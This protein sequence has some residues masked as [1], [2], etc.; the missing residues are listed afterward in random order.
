[1]DSSC[2]SFKTGCLTK[3]TGC[4]DSTKLCSDY[5]GIQSACDA[6]RGNNGTIRCWAP[7]TTVSSTCMDKTC[8]H[9]ASVTSNSDCDT[10]LR[11]CLYN[12]T[13]CVTKSELCGSYFGIQSQ[14]STFKANNG[15]DSCWNISTTVPGS[16]IVK[17][18]SHSGALTS[19]TDCKAFL[20][21]C[22]TNG[23]GCVPKTTACS[24]YTGTLA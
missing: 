22:L 23:S 24:A 17:N 19:D 4:I 14:C 1:L 15:V 11:G 12:G 3:G 6:F 8:H 20:E 21:G 5:S 9:S 7:S 13:G 16:C 18:C 2:N 10:F